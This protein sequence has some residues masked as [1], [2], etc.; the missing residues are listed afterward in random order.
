VFDL[1]TCAKSRIQNSAISSLGK[2]EC[3]LGIFG[4][5]WEAGNLDQDPTAITEVWHQ[6]LMPRMNNEYE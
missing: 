4:N 6:V 3:D 2:V 5:G 1:K